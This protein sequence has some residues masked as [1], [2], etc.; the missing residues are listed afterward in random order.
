M[1][2]DVEVVVVSDVFRMVVAIVDCAE[3][4]V[5]VIIGVDVVGFVAKNTIYIDM[6]I[7]I[8][9]IAVHSNNPQYKHHDWQI[10]LF[11]LCAV[12]YS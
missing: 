6:Y 9:S 1:I 11:I 3:L 12:L 7:Y 5:G 8:I 10:S 4:V 2:P